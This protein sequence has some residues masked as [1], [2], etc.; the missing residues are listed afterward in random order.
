MSEQVQ[1]GR[2]GGVWRRVRSWS[3]GRGGGREAKLEMW[4]R[5]QVRMITEG[6]ECQAAGNKEERIAAWPQSLPPSHT[7]GAPSCSWDTFPQGL[8][9]L[10][11]LSFSKHTL[12]PPASSKAGW[13]AMGL[14]P[15]AASCSPASD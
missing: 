9:V 11:I 12:R 14:K 13:K 5:T 6:G 1:A 4:P 8:S 3:P 15:S 2:E 7:P 10:Q